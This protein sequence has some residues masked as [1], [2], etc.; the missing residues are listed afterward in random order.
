MLIL[1]FKVNI[2][3]TAWTAH[4]GR[5]P[6]MSTWKVLSPSGS[7][8]TCFP[9]LR[10]NYQTYLIK[11]GLFFTQKML[12]F[13]GIP[14]FWKW[15]LLNQNFGVHSVQNGLILYIYNKSHL[16]HTLMII[17]IIL[18]FPCSCCRNVSDSKF[19]Y[20]HSKSSPF[21]QILG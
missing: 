4:L 1:H 20:L 8:Q 19:S 15:E 5:I 9:S 3:T 18:S 2:W 17:D 6:T 13:H 7:K 21:Y 16:T 14:Q 11:E 12:I 10:K